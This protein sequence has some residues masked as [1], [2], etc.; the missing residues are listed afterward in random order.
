M[1]ASSCPIRGHGGAKATGFDIPNNWAFYQ[2]GLNGNATQRQ[3]SGITGLPTDHIL[4]SQ[5]DGSIFELG[6]MVARMP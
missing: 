5:V 2:E 1:P 3:W 6:R 4:R